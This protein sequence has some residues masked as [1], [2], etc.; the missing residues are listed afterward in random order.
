MRRG[1]A[2]SSDVARLAGVSRS[3]VSRTFTP[4]ASVSSDVRQ[5]VIEAA[6]ALGYRVNR[7]AQGLISDRSNLV[8]VVGAHL[9]HPFSAEQVSALSQALLGHGLQCMLLN[10]D[11]AD[12]DI[13]TLIE[14]MLEFRARA[15]VIMSGTPP[16]SIVEECVRNGVRVVLVN[17]PVEGIAA[18]TIVSD[19]AHGARLAADALLAAGCRRLAVVASASG[20]PSL[21]RRIESFCE[22]LAAQGLAPLVFAQGRT[23]YETGAAAAEAL[24]GEAI[25]GAFCVTD[26]IALGF[27]DH[28]RQALGRRIPEDLCVVGYD[29]IPQA[30]WGAYRLTTI[31]QDVPRMTQAIIA[32]VERADAPRAM[33][34]MTVPVS[35]VTRGTTRLIAG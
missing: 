27:M 21:T 35:L 4:G 25:D 32:A 33:R 17:K 8:G 20:T 3:A 16:T 2:T 11:G 26:L 29:D 13:A 14:R 12:A 6:E 5:R 7:L 28:A 15:V 22:H 9:N 24:A 18:D 30:A 19:D 1:F 10:A 31:R 23:G 34:L